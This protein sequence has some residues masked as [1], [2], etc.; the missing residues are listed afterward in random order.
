VARRCIIAGLWLLALL[1]AL[2]FESIYLS[3]CI[4]GPKQG[5]GAA[6]SDAANEDCTSL[7]VV[8]WVACWPTLD[9]V[10]TF[11][12]AHATEIAAVVAAIATAV[13]AYFTA[14]LYRATDR[15][16]DSAERQ[17]GK[18]QISID[19]ERRIANEQI[20]KMGAYVAEASRAA[21]AMGDIA[22]AMEAANKLGRESIA[23]GQRAWLKQHVTVGSPLTYDPVN[24]GMLTLTLTVVIE[25]VG[26]SPAT[27]AYFD[28]D[29]I[30][31]GGG[32]GKVNDIRAA[33]RELSTKAKN[34]QHSVLDDVI[35]PGDTYGQHRTMSLPR[36][37]SISSLR[38][39]ISSPSFSSG[40][41]IIN[42][43]SRKSITRRGSPTM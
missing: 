14:T 8:I 7:G 12:G 18:I 21:D 31:R 40:A 20:D 13:V 5:D 23:A 26:R 29:L 38:I 4:I 15:L 9:A 36:P 24:N 43:R 6:Q 42:S 17:L 11:G 30:V 32:D 39:S 34:R 37:R 25:N 1:T 28:T 16:W 19:Q 35:F 10:L 22:R 33:Q 27:N 2:H 41:L 3:P